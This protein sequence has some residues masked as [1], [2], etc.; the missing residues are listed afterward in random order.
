MAFYIAPEILISLE[1]LELPEFTTSAE[2]TTKKP[3]YIRTVGAKEI[4]S[5]NEV[6]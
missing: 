3:E 5:A 6:K 4:L 2:T 1:A